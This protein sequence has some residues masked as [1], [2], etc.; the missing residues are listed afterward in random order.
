M[1][2]RNYV[3]SPEEQNFSGTPQRRTRPTFDATAPTH[4]V[5]VEDP[6]T[7][8]DVGVSDDSPSAPTD[9][10]G[11]LRLQAGMMERRGQK[12]RAAALRLQAAKLERGS[13]D[14]LARTKQR[15]GKRTDAEQAQRKSARGF[16][17]WVVAGTVVGLFGLGAIAMRK[18]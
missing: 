6:P 11:A 9:K 15:I 7:L 4:L 18:S 16:S 1:E 17:G 5:S 8:F 3:I 14:P 10:A 2:R 13:A 12:R